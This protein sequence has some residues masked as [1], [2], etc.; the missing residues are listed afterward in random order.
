M[1]TERVIE[2]HDVGYLYDGAQAVSMSLESVE[3]FDEELFE[4]LEPCAVHSSHH[5]NTTHNN[6]QHTAEQ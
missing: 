5:L 4:L 3:A 2:G 6:T 1:E